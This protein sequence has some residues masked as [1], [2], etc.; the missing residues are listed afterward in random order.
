MRH[1]PVLVDEVLEN[2]NIRNGIKVID[3]TLGD[4]GHSEAILDK[5][6]DKGK[7]LG[8]DADP[9]SML[10]AKRNLYRFGDSAIF[11][12]DNFTNL[13]KITTENHFEPDAILMDLG[14]STPQFK[15]RG[16]GFSFE[17]DE[18]LDM[19][20]STSEGD[21][22]TDIVNKYGEDELVEMLKYNAEE[23]FYKEIAREIIKARESGP[24]KTS[25]ELAEIVLRVYREKIGTD[26]EIPWIGGIHPATK[27]F[28]ALRIQVNN[29]LG[30]LES[31]LPQ[32]IEILKKDGRLVVITFHSLEDRIVKRVFQKVMGKTVSVVNKKPITA[33]VEEIKNNPSARSAKLRVIQKI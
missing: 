12:R 21:T 1:I 33:S 27:T 10:R 9:E 14:W 8:I 7:L 20:Y 23:K 29:E 31:V 30:V 28:Q 11:I 4:G 5:I 16:R 6:G 25:F 3:C 32:A 17:K 19:R 18:P 13:R 2:L 26:K 22:A 15:E 24:I